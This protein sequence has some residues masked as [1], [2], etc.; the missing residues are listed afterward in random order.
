[1]CWTVV[2]LIL[3]ITITSSNILAAYS[4]KQSSAAYHWVALKPMD[5]SPGVEGI[6]FIR[7]VANRIYRPLLLIYPLLSISPPL[8]VGLSN[9]MHKRPHSKVHWPSIRQGVHIPLPHWNG[10]HLAILDTQDDA[11]E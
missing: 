6:P 10:L 11:A 2:Y 4:I 3:L 8:V 1:M 9:Q 7:L 5:I